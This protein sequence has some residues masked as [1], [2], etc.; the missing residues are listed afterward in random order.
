MQI[1]RMPRRAAAAARLAL[2]LA[3]CASAAPA[4]DAASCSVR[5]TPRADRLTGGAGDDQLYGGH[6][7]DRLRG[8]AGDD[9]LIAYDGSADLVDCGV[10]DDVAPVDRRDRVVGCEHVIAPRSTKRAKRS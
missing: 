4:A 1:A 9:Q 5:G 7:A 2:A 6:D 8:G 10:G 3:V